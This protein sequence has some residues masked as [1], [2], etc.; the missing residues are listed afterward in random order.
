LLDVAVALSGMRDGEGTLIGFSIVARDITH[1]LTVQTELAAACADQEVMA[2]RDRIARDLHDMVIQRV[3]GAALA[4]QGTI[5]LISHSEATARIESVID[6]LDATIRELRGAIF[7]LRHPQQATSIQLLGLIGTA[8][9]ELGFAP[10]VS[11]DGPID[12]AIPDQIAVHLLA[13]VQEALS[14]ITRHAHASAVEVTLQIGTDL[15][16]E[17]SDNGRGFGPTTRASGLANMRER[18]QALDGT[19]E[20][21]SQPG[22]G[23]R[24]RWRIPL[25]RAWDSPRTP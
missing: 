2:D 23:T 17:V 13:V 25:R 16:L 22:A 18:A 7:D 21:V 9:G 10:T 6:E 15:D 11:F 3:F 1:Q 8:Q 4:L 12:A 24:I 14:N 19:C 5:G 20:V